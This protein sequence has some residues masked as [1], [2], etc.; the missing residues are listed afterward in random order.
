MSAGGSATAGTTSGGSSAGGMASGGSSVGG[1]GNPG[2]CFDTGSAY[3]A[4]PY[5]N[6]EGDVVA[7][8]ELEG[9]VNLEA[10]AISNTKPYVDTS[11]EALRR[12]GRCYA[13][14]HVSEFF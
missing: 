6:D 11:L 1:S 9:Y 10:D 3:P 14:V 4:G 12:T 8:L 5:G 7:N 2:A 13:V